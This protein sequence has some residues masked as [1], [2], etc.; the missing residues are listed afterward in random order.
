M[1][2]SHF[3]QF[4]DEATVFDPSSDAVPGPDDDGGR[5]FALFAGAAATLAAAC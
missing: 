4:L 3:Q 1:A 5:T 2:T